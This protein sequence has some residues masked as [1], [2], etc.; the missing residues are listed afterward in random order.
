MERL[1]KMFQD[2]VALTRGLG[3]QYIWIDSLCSI[4]Q[5][6]ADWEQQS[7]VMADIYDGC[8]LNIVST[9]TRNGHEGC[10]GA[11]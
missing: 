2:A 3:V 7:A 8:Y 10:F 6:K 4:Q 9:R 1:P 11:R 5:D